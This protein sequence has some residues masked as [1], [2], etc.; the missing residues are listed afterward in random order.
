MPPITWGL[1][2][3]N[4]NAIRA[5][6]LADSATKADLTGS[7]TLPDS[8]LLGLH[9]AVNAGL[10][11][12]VERFFLRTVA[13]SSAGYTVAVAYDDGTS[14]PPVVARAAV[15]RATH[16]EGQVYDLVGVGDFADSTGR[17]AIGD[18]TDV[19]RAPAGQFHFTRAGGQ[20]ESDCVRPQLRSVTSLSV[21]SG[22]GRSVRIY[23]DVEL[24]AGTNMRV[25]VGAGSI[26][27]DAV[28]GEGLVEDCACGDPLAP[29]VRTINGI[30]P[31]DSGNFRLLGNDCLEVDP[32]ANGV[33]LADVCSQPCCGCTELDAL[34]QELE[35]LGQQAQA[36]QSVVARLQG[37]V[38]QTTQVILGSRLGDDPCLSC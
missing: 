36:L 1:D 25:S 32:I 11:L 4:H 8:F 14:A 5:Y 38:D 24:V 6:P 13:L 16:S 18:P 10:S 23:G 29:P 37:S 34:K 35:H 12:E 28:A 22:T 21:V 27:F 33:R 7:F 2:W 17:V 20:L 3:A 9:L 31:D 30:P 15:P 19:D 26:R